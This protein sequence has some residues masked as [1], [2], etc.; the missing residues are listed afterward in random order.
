MSNV[1]F[2]KGLENNLPS[3]RNNETFYVTTDTGKM[4]LGNIRVGGFYSLSTEDLIEG[5][6]TLASGQL[7]FVY[8]E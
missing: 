1:K 7:Y 3:S 4:F 2:S 8:E 6:S 5:Q